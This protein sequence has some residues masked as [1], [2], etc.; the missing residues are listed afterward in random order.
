MECVTR[1]A[2]D[3]Y[4]DA[5][6][7]QLLRN[8]ARHIRTRVHEARQAPHVAAI[9]WP[10]ELLQ[11]ALDAGPR[12]G[13]SNV[14]V[15]IAETADNVIFE[16]DGAPFSSPELAALLSGGSSKEFG[17]EETTGRFGTG[18]LVTHVLAERAS[19]AGIL[20]VAGA[21]EQFQLDLDRGGDE[22]SILANIE[23][24]NHAIERAEPLDDVAGI[25]SARFVYPVENDSTLTLGVAAFLSALP[26]LYGTRPELGEVHLT[27]K[28]GTTQTWSAGPPIEAHLDEGVVQDRV[29]H[30][31]SPDGELRFRI[32]RAARGLDARAAALVLLV[33]ADDR[34]QVVPPA[35]TDPKVYREYPLRG[36][37][38]VPVNLVFDGNFEPDQERSRVLMNEGDR[39][40]LSEAFDAGVIAVQYACSQSWDG[41]HLLA[42]AD[43]PTSAFDLDD[44]EERQWWSDTLR[45]F[46]TRLSQLSL[47]HAR[48]GYLP[49]VAAEGT[50]V[51]FLL[52][53]LA[54][55]A[56]P[57]ETTIER[58]WP[59]ADEARALDPP[60]R[61]LA[62]EWSRIADGWAALG[63]PVSQVPVGSLGDLTRGKAQELSTFEVDTKPEDW[64]AR[65]VDVVGEC[66]KQRDGSEPGILDG[67]LPNQ[68]GRLC[69][70]SN[71][72]RDADV[73]EELKEIGASI[74]M[75]IRAGLL[76]AALSEAAAAPSLLYAAS[77]LAIAVPA[78]VDAKGIRDE[79]INHIRSAL[80]ENAT[81]S[82]DDESLQS[83]SARLLN[84][85]RHRAG[86]DA[87]EVARQV[88]LISAGKKVVYWARER[89][90]MAP[91]SSWAP[92]A[93]PFNEAYPLDRILDEVYAQSDL[94][95]ALDQWGIAHSD[96]LIQVTP[97]ELTGPRLAE[98]ALDG[99]DTEGVTIRGEAFSQIALLPVEVMNHIQDVEQAQALLG[100]AL[101]HIA[102][103][104]S[105]WREHRAATGTRAREP[106]SVSVRRALWIGDLR[107]RAWVPVR[108]EDDKPAKVA[109]DAANLKALLDPTW[110]VDNADAIEL[111]TS[112]FGF[113]ELDLRLLGIGEEAQSRVRQGLARLLEAGGAD[114]AFYES[115]AH[116]I[117]ARRARARD[118]ERSRRMGYAVQQ[119][120]CDALESHGLA[121]TLVDHG[122]D[123]EVAAPGGTATI[124]EG[125][126][127][128]G[129]GPYFV[130]VKATSTGPARLTPTQAR[131]A[132]EEAD[133]YVLC[134]VD[135]RGV[136]SERLDEEWEAADVEPL[137]SLVTDI[138][139][140]VLDTCTLVEQARLRDIGIRNESALRYEIQPTTWEVGISISD[141]VVEI[142]GELS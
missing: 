74:D 57:D 35:D 33:P 42:R 90:M 102:R 28:D 114:P 30:A 132:A 39:H 5:R 117:E 139:S 23:A 99:S 129:V 80:P 45:D 116:E 100:L 38:F 122:F 115:L 19:I 98:I 56:G 32:I 50:H 77:A 21:F 47:V 46:A 112:C 78:V 15:R 44:G 64:I 60:V 92:S 31:T 140:Q 85:E 34:W 25:R 94:V 72:R 63:V 95:R 113:D 73:P 67:L 126:V 135:L 65:Y 107:S 121:V 91:V 17:S 134:V 49:A 130:E 1:E 118:V 36:S 3:R 24:C 119:A 109:A 108:G 12:D 89:T 131:T 37:T 137:A 58:M 69:S 81:C 88:P 97:T 11:N 106:V 111:L 59:L 68:H 26:Y 41:A 71:V 96:P 6:E 123:Y 127:R 101:C 51:D 29:I 103:A 52:P 86:P 84:Y 4:Q 20:S 133:R 138:G 141:W 55:A 75:D 7:H 70:A 136:P 62:A 16:H 53:R 124:E 87:S 82:A 66:W 54:A 27:R 142:A 120:I 43:Q 105:T 79:L 83:A 22:D 110:L 104:D 125:A 8:E 13:A 18:F 2:L 48:D 93:R 76:S 40:A 128:F 9:R 10:F 14:T 61:E